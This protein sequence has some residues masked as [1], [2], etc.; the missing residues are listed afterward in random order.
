[1]KKFN[2]FMAFIAIL[3]LTTQSVFAQPNIGNDCFPVGGAGVGETGDKIMC[4][5]IISDTGLGYSVGSAG[6]DRTWDFSSAFKTYATGAV[7]GRRDWIKEAATSLP[8]LIND[9]GYTL[10]YE[11]EDDMLET[12]YVWG[13]KY[14]K[15]NGDAYYSDY[16]EDSDANAFYTAMAAQ[17]IYVKRPV[18][19]G[20]S[21]SDNGI[22]IGGSLAGFVTVDWT[23]DVDAYGTVT[24]P[25]GVEY[26]AMRIKRTATSA[27]FGGLGAFDEAEY[28]WYSP[29]IKGPIVYMYDKTN[30]GTI[31]RVRYY[32]KPVT[33]VN[34]TAG[35]IT[36]DGGTY[37]MSTNLE[38]LPE[39]AGLKD[40]TWT[41]E[42]TSYGASISAA[43]VVTAS[44]VD[45]G[46]GTITIRATAIGGADVYG[47]ADLV[48]SGQ[49]NAVVLV[50]SISIDNKTITADG[51]TCAMSAEVLP[52]DADDK[53]V[54]WSIEGDAKGNT[55]N[56]TTGV[57][58]ASG[59]ETGNGTITVK[60]TNAASGVT[61]TATVTISGQTVA[62]ASLTLTDATITTDGGTVD[63][64]GNITYT[65]TNA[66]K[67]IVWA[68]TG[69]AKG[70]SINSTT[71]VVTASGADGGDGTITVKATSKNYNSV[72]TTAE[73][74]I[75]GQEN[76]V[77]LVTSIS[78]DNKTITADGGTCA[79]SAEV[80]PADADDKTVTWSIE[81][82]AKGNTINATTGVV[83]AS[84]L[85][86]GNG[87][88]TVKATAQDGSTIAGT[89]TVTITGQTVAVTSLS[90]TAA[91][92]TTDGGTVDMS[93][94]IGY[95]P[96][97]A[98]KEIEWAITGNANGAS[99]NSTTGVV[100]ASGA[101]GGDGT[102]T[103]KATSK[104]YNSVSTT[105][106]VVISGQENAVVLVT[107]ISIDNKTITA[108]GGTC[109]MSA[110]VLPADADDK[111]V[112][113][114]IEGDAKGNTINATTGVVTASGLETGNGTITVK[115]TAQ[116]GS[117][118]AG[119]A[120]VTI[121]GQTVP[122]ESLSLSDATITTDGGT[123]DMSGKIGYNPT[124]ADKE[125]VWA[126]TGESYGASIN[127]ST[128]V[129]TAGGSDDSNGT[130]TVKAISKNYTTK[131]AT[132]SVKISNQESDLVT[133][134]VVSSASG[135]I[136]IDT[137]EG[138]LQMQT[139]I[140][141]T[142]ASNP[143]IVWS[144]DNTS[145]AT[146]GTNGVL[147]A[148]TNGTVVVT[149]TNEFSG[150]TGT[151]SITI[152][153]QTKMAPTV[154]SI[155]LL[156][157]GNSIEIK[158]D[159]KM[160]LT[161]ITG[162][163]GFDVN[164]IEGITLS[165]KETDKTVIILTLPIVLTET[166]ELSVSYSP[167]K[168]QSSSEVTLAGFDAQIYTPV[169]NSDWFI[170]VSV[171]VQANGTQILLTF[172]K[173]I[174]LPVTKEAVQG[175]SVTNSGNDNP[176][177]SVNVKSD[178]AMVIEITVSNIITQ[179]E[180]VVV[181]YNKENE[182]TN[183]DSK[184]LLDFAEE[185][186]VVNNSELTGIKTIAE[187]SIKISPNPVNNILRIEMPELTTYQISIID[188][189]GKKIIEKTINGKGNIDTK[190]LN[191]GIYIL[192]VNDGINTGT[193]IFIKK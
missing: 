59:L 18:T 73:V 81:G 170:P 107:S 21:E 109:A 80:L 51:G 25:G 129:V 90:L 44:G 82:D 115:A 158:F 100:T 77:V 136:I 49:E 160:D 123:V 111:T 52:A 106:E 89:A 124:N 166:V 113:W 24:L 184:K 4:L 75:S 97:D 60:A 140:T 163:G 36:T 38:V 128:G 50:T 35:T 146:I 85:E 164:G 23:Y 130:I 8:G 91:T 11:Y 70:A 37:D 155:T 126:I 154:T 173:N 189:T 116:D 32:I 1:M 6:T 27:G 179:G 156:P 108:D 119:T 167:G 96:T 105:A 150:V 78:I 186:T 19:Y 71:G 66:D 191:N 151:L 92:I 176:I 169:N 87:T 46:N 120:T 95:N 192:N 26:E 3:I 190:T 153:N 99:I 142:D 86:T 101:D 14:F 175:F 138:T 58:T 63:M 48:I 165:L 174:V 134:I 110:E 193:K 149:A 62:V 69:D 88:I 53:T 33:A 168:I 47:E 148:I 7:I 159:Q 117:T 118:I 65:P 41:I 127:N 39:D 5:R 137:E 178:D 187:S 15:N 74:V 16:Q 103:V 64:S 152:T 29:G 93:E 83:T 121:S 72:S 144:V 79:M 141:P 180:T 45:A 40:I 57:V 76:A 177:L 147:T 133:A 181:T 55:I 84:G 68:I 183:I 125:I 12:G 98:D 132:A 43:G 112:T 131:T 9:K 42:G 56:A 157:V 162:A 171:E 28:L 102:I 122:V 34:L 172:T 143:E 30:D 145:I 161:G 135:K 13:K 104:N 17:Q 54:T 188:I 22:D 185:V 2:L 182:I 10:S 114:S 94:K 67:E 20:D 61:G 139:V 31:T